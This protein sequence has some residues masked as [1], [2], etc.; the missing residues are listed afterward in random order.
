MGK[1]G[2]IKGKKWGKHKKMDL[3]MEEKIILSLFFN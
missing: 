2:N 3:E 1:N